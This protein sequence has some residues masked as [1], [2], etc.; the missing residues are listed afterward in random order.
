M[1]QNQFPQ[2]ENSKITEKLSRELSSVRIAAGK[3]MQAC[4]QSDLLSLIP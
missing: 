3:R 4:L 2:P 1:K